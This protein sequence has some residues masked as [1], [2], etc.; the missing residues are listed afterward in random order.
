MAEL[1]RRGGARLGAVGPGAA[2][3]GGKARRDR[4]KEGGQMSCSG[5]WLPVGL[6]QDEGWL[7]A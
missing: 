6:G 4:K 5:E 7:R 1:G 3:H 2:R